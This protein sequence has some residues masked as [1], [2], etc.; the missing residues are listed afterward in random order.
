M[1]FLADFGDYQAIRRS[2]LAGLSGNHEVYGSYLP[3]NPPACAMRAGRLVK[4]E[5]PRSPYS[6]V[7]K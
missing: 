4:P 6:L 7:N 5:F 3:E 2:S 1:I